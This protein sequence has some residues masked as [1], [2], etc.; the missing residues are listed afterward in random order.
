MA[1][2]NNPLKMDPSRT[3]TLRAKWI[4]DM[5]ARFNALAKE[6]VQLVDKDDAFGL[7]P[8]PVVT[9]LL[10]NERK[11]FAFET[12]AGKVG[13]FREWFQERINAGVLELEDG[14]RPKNPW[15][16]EYVNSA[17]RKGIS[18]GYEQVHKE[19]LS[20]KVEFYT[21]SK[22]EFLRDAFAAPETV[23]KVELLYTRAYDKLAGV[24]ADMAGEMSRI[25]AE[26]IASGR[27][28]KEVARELR[29]SIQGFG[30]VRAARV[31][32]TEII[33]AHA[34]GQLDSYEALGV[35]DVGVEAEWSTA[36]DSRVCPQ[37]LA[38]EGVI[39]KVS[40]A[41][42]LIPLHPNCRCAWVPY[43]ESAVKL[44]NRWARWAPGLALAA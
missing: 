43:V 29:T 4:A 19:A 20:K 44:R 2:N 15:T 21:N 12:D 16:N 24:T 41:H 5:K 42:G 33:N 7:T 13:R 37:C 9:S 27:G 14:A 35:E 32:R 1:N 18:R 22:A 30:K 26:G 39:Y 31:A 3:T 28:S 11:Q 10:T 25:L 34:E 6:V 36:G 23:S 40:E 38:N 17:Y 8:S